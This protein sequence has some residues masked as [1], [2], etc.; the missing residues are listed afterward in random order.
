MTLIGEKWKTLIIYHLKNGPMRSSS[1]QHLLIGISNKMFTQTIRELEYY[2]LVE[3]IV[4]PVVPPKVE[5]RLTELGLSVLPII[6]ELE[7]WGNDISARF[8]Q[9]EN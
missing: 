2:D 6:M 8:E 4:Y 5:Y 1:L 3:R 7:K 9:E